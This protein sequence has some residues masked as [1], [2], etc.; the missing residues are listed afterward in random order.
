[1]FV[2]I[3]GYYTYCVCKVCLQ[4]KC[5]LDRADTFAFLQVYAY[6]L[7]LYTKKPIC[8]FSITVL[9]AG[10][11]QRAPVSYVAPPSPN[12]TLG[13]VVLSTTLHVTKFR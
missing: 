5:E 10:I 2:H 11:G 8:F 3:I 4:K 13:P 1:M 9:R 7:F 6:I 12:T